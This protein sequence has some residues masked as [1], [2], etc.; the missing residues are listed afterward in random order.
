MRACSSERQELALSLEELVDDNTRHKS[1]GNASEGEQT[2]E[3]EFESEKHVTI[4]FCL[5]HSHGNTAFQ[6]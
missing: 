2:N 5:G 1:D 4:I 3:E 6:L